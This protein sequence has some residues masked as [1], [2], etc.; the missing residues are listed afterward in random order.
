MDRR[1]FVA[2]TGAGAALVAGLPVV[3]GPFTRRSQADH[4]VPADKRLTEEWVRALFARGASTWYS[5]A[6]L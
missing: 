4:F 2:V 1:E 6:D 3:A 5:G